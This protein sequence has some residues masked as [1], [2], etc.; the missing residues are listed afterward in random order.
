MAKQKTVQLKHMEL[1]TLKE[2]CK[3][4][5]PLLARKLKGYMNVKADK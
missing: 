1:N 3:D 5:H 2:L 4:K